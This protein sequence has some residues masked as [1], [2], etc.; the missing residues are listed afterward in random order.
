MER[1]NLPVHGNFDWPKLLIHVS[2]FSADDD[3]HVMIFQ[4]IV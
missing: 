1:E 4:N 2:V 3:V